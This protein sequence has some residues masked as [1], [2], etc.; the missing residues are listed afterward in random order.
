VLGSNVALGAE[1]YKVGQ[2]VG[3][4]ITL[5]PETPKWY[6]VMNMKP[7]FK[8]LFVNT[9]VLTNVI[10]ALPGVLAL[11]LPI[12]AVRV[13]VATLPCWI[14]GAGYRVFAQVAHGVNGVRTRTATVNAG[15]G[16]MEPKR[17]AAIGASC[18]D[19]L[20]SLLA[21]SA[22]KLALVFAK[23]RDLFAALFAS[24]NNCFYF[25]PALVG[26]KLTHVL[27]GVKVHCLT[28]TFARPGKLFNFG[29]A[30]FGGAVSA[31][32]SFSAP[33]QEGFTAGWASLID[34]IRPSFVGARSTAKRLGLIVR[35]AALLAQ[36]KTSCQMAISTCV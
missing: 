2:L 27:A 24:V 32:V 33:S 30:A 20:K 8:F 3:L 25:G 9:T 22:A 36:H 1:G 13:F 26:A 7:F 29:W 11:H 19:S 16:V 6:N 12:R 31:F 14:V 15:P 23:R 35:F 18:V 17:F 10:V 5:K 4:Q 28:A 34:L 21:L